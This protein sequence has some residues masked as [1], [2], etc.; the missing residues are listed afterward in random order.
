MCVSIFFL[1]YLW[2]ALSTP[3]SSTLGLFGNIRHHTLY[4]TE[5][6]SVREMTYLFV[7]IAVSVINALAVTLSH[8]DLLLTNVIFIYMHTPV[9]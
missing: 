1:I 6:M 7:I 3:E 5:S 4:R 2:G 8:G 9:S